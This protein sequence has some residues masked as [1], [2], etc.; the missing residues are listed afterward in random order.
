MALVLG[1]NKA[2]IID[3]AAD[4]DGELPITMEIIQRDGSADTWLN[5][6]DAKKLIAHLKYIFEI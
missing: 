5:E 4:D 3:D 2:L 6:K 1:T